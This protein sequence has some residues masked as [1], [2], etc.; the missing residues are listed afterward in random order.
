MFMNRIILVV[1]LLIAI[2]CNVVAE[3]F[4]FLSR[5]YPVKTS[6][7]ADF[8]TIV[9]VK[10]KLNSSKS[11][12][13]DLYLRAIYIIGN[14]TIT[15]Y[16]HYSGNYDGIAKQFAVNTGEKVEVFLYL[17][18]EEI[19]EV[20][21]LSGSISLVAGGTLPLN[22]KPNKNIFPGTVWNAE[23][24]ILFKITKADEI[25]QALRV[26]FAFTENFEFDRLFLRIKVISPEQGI[27]VL[28]KEIEV[29]TSDFLEY[30]K[31]TI[32]TEIPEIVVRIPG[33]YYL[34]ISHQMQNIRVNGIDNASYEL[35]KQ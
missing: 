7:K 2:H 31:N 3:D 9:D 17:N 6:F 25:N 30:S 23:D 35:I 11:K 22:S 15:D 21:N 29:N 14:D 32:K 4:A 13:R 33:I 1:L 28:S 19:E 12:R 26:N 10:F 27:V 34:Q 18:N 24:P 16:L 8:K 20:K 5:N